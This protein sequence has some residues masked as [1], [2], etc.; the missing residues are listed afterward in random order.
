MN[1]SQWKVVKGS[2]Y[3]SVQ[4]LSF[5]TKGTFRMFKWIWE[6]LIRGS[7]TQGLSITFIVEAFVNVVQRKNENENVWN[8]M[9]SETNTIF[10]QFSQLCLCCMW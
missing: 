9:E 3:L 6:N 2:I 5:Q 1:E 4:Q 8:K 7:S 10:S